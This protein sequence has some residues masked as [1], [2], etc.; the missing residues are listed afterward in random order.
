[1][2]SVMVAGG[3]WARLVHVHIIVNICK[4]LYIDTTSGRWSGRSGGKAGSKQ[5]R[6]PLPEVSC[7]QRIIACARASSLFFGT[8]PCFHICLRSCHDHIINFIINITNYS[9]T[10]I[11]DIDS[12]IVQARVKVC[13]A[14]TSQL[15]IKIVQLCSSRGNMYLLWSSSRA[16][17]SELFA[18]EYVHI[19]YIFPHE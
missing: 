19:V 16:K 3:T 10:I 11:P 12:I 1:M 18:W 15:R 6:F 4:Y 8:H 5:R 9:V 2:C 7:E 17:T 13:L 14:S